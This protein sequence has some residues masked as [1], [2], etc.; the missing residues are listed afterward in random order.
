MQMRQ[1]NTA[2]IF[3][4]FVGFLIVIGTL[5]LPGSCKSLI[6]AKGW[7]E[8]EGEIS[9]LP[10]QQPVTVLRDKHGIPHIY[11]QNKHDLLVAQGFVHAQDRLWQM[12]TFRRVVSGRLSEFA[13]EGRVNLDTF[14]RMLGFPALRRKAYEALSAEDRAMAQAYAD[15]VNAYIRLLGEDLPLEFQSSDHTPEEY[16]AEDTISL[17]V[18]NS[19]MFRENYRPELMA[20]L[21][22]QGITMEEWADIYPAFPNATLPDDAYFEKLRS[23]EIGTVLPEVFSFFQALPE[24]AGAGG[25]NMWISKSGPGGKPLFAN[26]QH[27]G[28]SLPNTW[29]LCHLNAPGINA[30]GV[31]AA[32]APGIMTGHTDTMAWGFAIFPIDFVDLFV[33]RLDP[34]D[35]TRYIVGDQTLEMEEEE[36]VIGLPEGR[37]VSKTVYHTIFGPIITELQPGTEGAVALRSYGTVRGKEVID[38]T[39]S[40]VLR[41]MEAGS[42]A[43]MM[44]ILAD[45]KTIGFSVIMGDADGNIGW[46]T[47]GSVPKRSGYSGRLPADG[48]SGLNDWQG[49]LSVEQMPDAYNPPEGQIIN[50]NNR[51]IPKDDPYVF[52]FMW[53]ADYR[54]NRIAML[55]EDLDTPTV[56]DFRRM[57][58]DVHSLQADSILPKL[59]AYS[60]EDEKAAAALE[61]L[62]N[63]D[64]EVRADSPGAAVYEVFLNQ[65]V[66]ALLEDE[67]G[68]NLFPYFHIT[69]KKYLIQDVILDRP[70]SPLWDRKDTPDRETPQ[71]I[72]EMALSR[73]YSWLEEELGR[74]P[75]KW[76]WGKLHYYYWKHAGGTS[77]FKA[78]L[79]NVGPIPAAG[80]F[81]TVNNNAYIAAKDEYKVTM[82]PGLRMVIPLDDVNAMKVSMP[83]G[84]SCQPGHE[85]YDDL[86]DGWAA[87]ELF[88]FP[89]KRADV[90]AM[91]VSKLL[92]SP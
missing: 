81:N 72:L 54:R 67:L 62:K 40:S 23:V 73:A 27:L 32:G 22:R 20:L 43:E 52:S 48:S 77:W 21:G 58:M 60:F 34:Q 6:L 78:W 56:E 11:A 86:V 7:P 50:T 35:P 45:M 80:D 89:V 88:D 15:G 79:L 90:E 70:D 74:N 75:R 8:Y 47:T 13:G 31:S 28:I 92:L 2:G 16:T 3:R 68:E 46:Q 91:T 4:L 9:N 39:L 55:L 64:R 57:Q 83:L 85:H 69:L 25:T 61:M 19:W 5:V 53:S 26:D 51:T 30:A 33:L 44:D 65:W 49:F 82:L 66:R 71:Q 24:Q 17:I 37:S 14:C 63:W 10:V 1:V 38:G 59:F 76:K 87:G 18:L 41:F 12:E 42:V 36:L 29:Y 84:Q